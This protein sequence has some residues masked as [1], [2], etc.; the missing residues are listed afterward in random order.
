MEAKRPQLKKDEA[1]Q[2]CLSSQPNN[3]IGDDA[4][5]LFRMIDKDNALD[6]LQSRAT[7]PREAR[8]FL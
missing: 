6:R 4:N 5:V 1:S 8:A 3:L 2:E 7:L